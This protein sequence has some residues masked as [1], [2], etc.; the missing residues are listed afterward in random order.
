MNKTKFAVTAW[1]VLGALAH[2]KRLNSQGGGIPSGHLYAQLMEQFDIGM[3]N[4][5]VEALKTQRLVSETNHLLKILP[6]GEALHAKLDAI[7]S[8]K[9]REVRQ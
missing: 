9:G 4:L 1:V 6:E 7:L 2:A 8:Q 5:F 3:W